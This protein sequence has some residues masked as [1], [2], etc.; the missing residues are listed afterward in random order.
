MRGKSENHQNAGMFSHRF[1][2]D[3]P[4]FFAIGFRL[5]FF[6]VLSWKMAP[7]SLPF[8]LDA[9]SLLAPFSRPSPEIDFFMHFGR[10]LAHFWHPL[11]SKW[12]P[13]GSRWLPFGSLL[14]PFGSLFAPFGSLW[15]TFG[16]LFVEILRIFI[17][18]YTFSRICTIG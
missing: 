1:F 17:I 13:F 11:A 14:A 16:T 5:Y 9:E 7:K 8:H 4:R 15:L 2:F 3:F 12:L 10:P 18:F 6:I